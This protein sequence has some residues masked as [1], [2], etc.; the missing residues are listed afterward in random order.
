MRGPFYN[1]NTGV[2]GER[3]FHSAKPTLHTYVDPATGKTVTKV[4]AQRSV[5]EDGDQN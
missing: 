5:E 4:L 3:N 2:T 1:D